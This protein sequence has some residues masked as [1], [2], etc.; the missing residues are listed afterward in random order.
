MPRSTKS[1]DVSSQASTP[2]AGLKVLDL[3]RV[4][5]GPYCAMILG[6]MGAEVVK[7]EHPIGG[8]NARGNGPFFDGLS[9][10]FASINRGKTSVT[11]DFSTERGKEV[12]LALVKE[13]DVLVENFVPGTMDRLGLGNE[14]LRKLNPRLIYCAVSGFGQTGPYSHLP[15]VDVIVQGMGGI[16]SITGEPGGPPIRPGVSYGDIVAGLFATI[17]ILTAINERTVSGQGQLVD[18]SMMDCQVAVLENAFSRYFAGGDL[19]QPIGTRHPVTAPFQAFRASDGWFT[20][21]VLGGRVDKWPLFCSAIDRLDLIGNPDYGTGW[22]RV[23][24]YATLEPVLNEALRERTVAEWVETFQELEI[25][26]GPVNGIEEAAA[27]PQ[28]EAR[29][30][31][32]DVTSSGG[33][34]VRLVN[35]PI[36]LSRTPGVVNQASPE[37]GEQTEKVLADWLGLTKSAVASLRADGAV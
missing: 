36:K 2:L 28:V 29:E 14:T 7:I 22:L 32:V 27:D 4:L 12:L 6:D 8:D 1:P 24:N 18:I 21:A 20:V 23:Q 3:C 5:A 16:M 33:T 34:K 17:G 9:S 10:Y 35:T 26:S 31:F 19:P 13:A 25:P 15:A 30:M 37:L 11:L